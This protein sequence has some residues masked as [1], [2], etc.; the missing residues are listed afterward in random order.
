MISPL[1]R[2]FSMVELQNDDTTMEVDGS[3]TVSASASKK[4][5]GIR[6]NRRSKSSTTFKS[7]DKR[8]AR[9]KAISKAKSKSRK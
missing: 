3:N 9:K 6:K 4:A 5:K 2:S 8:A 7:L 1:I